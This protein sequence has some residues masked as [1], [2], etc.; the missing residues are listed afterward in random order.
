M[1]EENKVVKDHYK[2]T[3]RALF[4]FSTL[5]SIIAIIYYLYP[6]VRVVFG[7]IVIFLALILIVATAVFT[8]FLACTSEDYRRWVGSLWK[9][10]TSFYENGVESI[11]AITPYFMYVGFVSLAFNILVLVLSIIKRI[12]NKNGYLVIIIFT[13]IFLIINIILLILYYSNGM[14]LIKP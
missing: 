1:E 12:K 3:T 7:I 2:K 9:G 8:L 14:Q 4:V 10:A 13:S 6:L 5:F 11:N